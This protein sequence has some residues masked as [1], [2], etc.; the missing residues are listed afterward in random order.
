MTM[1]DREKRQRGPPLYALWTVIIAVLLL[2]LTESVQGNAEKDFTQQCNKC[3]CSWKSGKRNADCTN[4]GL[5]LIPDDLSSEL[6]VLDLS[7]NRIG[8]IRAF[9][10]MRA[11]Q[12]N[13]P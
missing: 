3:R 9:E 6:Q 5:D 4:Q 10:L 12:H 7:L 8:E 13:D 2:Q 1:D 11:H